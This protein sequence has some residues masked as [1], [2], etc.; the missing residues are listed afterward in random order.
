MNPTTRLSL[1]ARLGA[2]I[3]EPA[4]F[5]FA[6]L[7]GPVIYRTVR[8]YG[9]QDADAQDVTQQVLWSVKKTMA[10]RPH[11][12]ERARFRTWLA[13]VTKNASLN[14]MRT[15]RPHLR[16]TGDSNVQRVLE[17]AALESDQDQILD[18]EFEKEIFR[19]AAATVEAEF[20]PNTWKAFQLTA[21]EG[22]S[23][24]ETARL[25][26]KQVGTV[27]VARSRVMRR[28]REEVSRRMQ[29][30]DGEAG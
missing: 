2:G 25:L 10:I 3:D 4:W 26:S 8:I 9:L 6:S 19:V 27:Y 30:L 20:E 22:K 21:I 7:Y 13:K 18:Q 1:L 11:D 28:L 12:P 5:E 14:A 23:I 17:N 15:L 29:E 24:E 16:G